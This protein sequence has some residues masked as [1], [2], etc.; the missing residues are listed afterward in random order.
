MLADEEQCY[1]AGAGMC[2]D[3]RA[4]EV[5]INVLHTELFTHAFCDVFGV[6][7]A[8]AVADEHGLV[9][10]LNGGLFH[11]LH[12]RIK[13]LPSAAHLADRDEVALIIH[14]QNGFYAEQSADERCCGGNAAAAL[15]G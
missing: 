15:S 5:D 4:D 13:G 12:K 1:G 11:F 9:C 10:G 3:D 14:M 7:Q 8:I 2:A 6:C